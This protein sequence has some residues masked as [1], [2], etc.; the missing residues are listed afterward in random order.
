MKLLKNSGNKIHFTSLGCA[1]NLVDTEVMIGL[2]LK[3]GYEATAHVEEALRSF[4]DSI[5][6][7]DETQFAVSPFFAGL[8]RVPRVMG[9]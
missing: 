9:G 8:F 3:A 4:Q 2:V 1:R 5:L 6:Q 7:L